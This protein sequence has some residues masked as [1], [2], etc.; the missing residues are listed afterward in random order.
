MSAALTSC[1]GDN[2]L[3]RSG[4]RRV[5]LEEGACRDVEG[6]A[7]QLLPQRALSP[8]HLPHVV[9]TVAS[10]VLPKVLKAPLSNFNI[11]I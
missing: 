11:K 6:Q 7:A 9:T 4:L 5:R 1:L 3:E 2:S 10:P 8:Q